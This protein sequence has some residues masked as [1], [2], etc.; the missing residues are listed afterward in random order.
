M[1]FA[2]PTLVHWGIDDWQQPQDTWTASGMLGLHVADL[3]TGALAV[4]Q[5]IVFSVQDLTT[6]NWVES[7]RIIEIVA[8]DA[9]ATPGTVIQSADR[10]ADWALGE[11]RSTA[12]A[13]Q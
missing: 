13:A 1:S 7:D 2:E 6:G 8:E 3:E 12:I 10:S 11:L 4:G 5:R 9:V